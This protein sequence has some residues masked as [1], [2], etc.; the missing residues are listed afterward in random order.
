MAS[1]DAKNE[2]LLIVL[3]D[4]AGIWKKLA[5][6]SAVPENL[7][8]QAREF[9]AEFDALAQYRGKGAE[10]AHF[11]GETLFVQ[12]ARALPRLL[13]I[14]AQAYPSLCR[15]FAC[16]VILLEPIKSKPDS[17]GTEQKSSKIVR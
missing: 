7:R 3:T 5:E 10:V 14:Q 15:L 4:L 13:E 2:M 8:L 9:G 6:N 17:R 1:N 11:M 12:M 16:A